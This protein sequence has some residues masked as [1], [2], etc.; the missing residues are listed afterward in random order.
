MSSIKEWINNCYLST[1]RK[2]FKRVFFIILAV[3]ILGLGQP[4]YAIDISDVPMATQVQKAPPNIMFV[5]DNS[6]SMDWSFM[7]AGQNQGKWNGN[8]NYV[9]DDAGDNEYGDVLSGTERAEWQSQ[10]S[11]A[12]KI[13]YNPQIDYQPWPLP[14]QD[15]ATDEIDRMQNADPTTPISNPYFLMDGDAGTDTVTLDM[16]D[17]YYTVPVVVNEVIVDNQDGLPGF[18]TTGTWGESGLTPEWNASSFYTNTTGDTAVFTPDIPQDGSFDVYTWW[19]CYTD[20]DTN[21]MITVVHSGAVPDTVL[22]N[23][24]SALDN[25]PEPGV[26]GEWLLI[27]TYDFLAGTTGSVTIS[28]HAGSI[29][30]STVAD[31]VRFVESGQSIAGLDIYN[32]H[33]YTQEWDDANGNGDGI[34][35][36]DELTNYL[37][38]FNNG[39]REVYRINDLNTNDIIDHTG[40]LESIAELP[41]SIRPAIYDWVD[42]NGDGI[43]DPDEVVFIEYRD[44]ASELQNFANWYSYYRKRELAAKAAVANAIV[45]S[46]GIQVGFYSLHDYNNGVTRQPVLPV[47]LP[48]Q[49]DDTST[50]LTH[51]YMMDS[52]GGT[53]LRTSFQNV[54]RYFDA[55]DG[56]DGGLGNSPYYAADEGGACQHSFAIVMT[57]GFWNGG[58]PGVGNADSGEGVPYADGYSD[59]LADVA[60]YYYNRDLSSLPN[61]VPTTDCDDNDQQHLI[62]F[63][64]SF[65]LNGD[66]NPD[67]Y[68]YSND[69]CFL[70]P[71]AQSPAWPNPQ[72]N[73]SSTI[74][75]L[76]HAA[77]NGRGEYYSA[78]DPEKLVDSL[79]GIFEA[80]E[81]ITA[82]GAAVAINGDII[83]ADT[84]VFQTDYNSETWTGDLVAYP[85]E[86]DANGEVVFDQPDWRASDTLNSV[87]W[88]TGRR[89]VTYNDATSS[90]VSFRYNELSTSQQAMLDADE[91]T[92]QKIVDYIRGDATI[93]G[94]RQRLDV[95]FN[96]NILGDIVHSAP[97]IIDDTIFV[98]ANDGMLH[99]F[100]IE[101]GLERFAYIPNL[102]FGNLSLLKEAVFDHRFF[103]DATPVIQENVDYGGSDITLLVGGLGKGGKGFYALNVTH[104]EN[105]DGSSS[106]SSV[107]SVVL[108]EYPAG[109]TDDDMGFS[110]SKPFIVKSN[111]SGHGWVVI[112]GNGY[113]SANGHAVLY[114][115]DVDG[116]LIR[117]IDT[118]VSDSSDNGLSSPTVID[119]DEDYKADVVYAGDLEGNLWK[120]DLHDTDPANW[121][122]AFGG[123]PLFT[124]K[125]PGSNTSDYQPII[126]KPAVMSHCQEHGFIVNF[127]TG[128]FLGE[129]DRTDMDVQSLY[130]IWDF[131]DWH[132][133]PLAN[134]EYLGTFTRPGLSNLPGVTLLEQ[135]QIATGTFTTF[136][137]DGSDGGDSVFE[138]RVTSDESDDPNYPASSI[139]QADW[140]TDGSAPSPDPTVHAGWF[141]DLPIPGERMFSNALIR[142]GKFISVTAIP[143]SSFCSGGGY[144][145][146]NEFD[147]CDGSRLDAPPFDTNGDGYITSGDRIEFNTPGNTEWK[148]AT[149]IIHPV[150][151]LNIDRSS[152]IGIPGPDG[153]PSGLELKIGTDSGSNG[154]TVIVETAPRRGVLYWQQR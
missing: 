69:P 145:I 136:G 134:D 51:L 20:R 116:T 55:T 31:A 22:M 135:V 13:Y 117:K 23:Q 11:G 110:Y 76:W 8:R 129:G 126:T 77:V 133:D 114:V 62:T 99:A 45:D 153:T 24:R 26:C 71:D 152:I 137:T 95:E 5:L 101:T 46:T 30:G 107:E 72:P 125:G 25:T 42:T 4:G 96:I 37:V 57:D 1:C 2:S 81:S 94:F 74:D 89:I 61:E 111:A 132:P 78:S 87:N 12:N 139:Y 138:L 53:P 6:G 66:L 91:A 47:R 122:V 41:E 88:D 35:D 43:E 100:N 140:T 127:G 92:A 105:I 141:F 143:D 17:V 79:V 18:A 151:L 102:V 10:W 128:K 15:P 9:F 113:N 58:S 154:L 19:N 103:V 75:D 84:K 60:M 32:A 104:A 28:R 121:T 98:G 131:A 85:L 14:D 112:F 90:G 150:G 36:P 34:E 50:L 56:N 39:V 65:G 16:T 27:G 106:E 64:I 124:A 68:N 115:L 29:G 93:P 146:V 38:N 108:W 52:D 144:S 67:D 44:T 70:D 148:A 86:R 120:F 119:L 33:Y 82:S 118:L 40:E 80:I 48:G 130:G 142:G 63:S 49:V 97:V 149:G 54:G 73:L 3:S 147:A 83:T 109:I 7:A 59:T 123:H 21:A